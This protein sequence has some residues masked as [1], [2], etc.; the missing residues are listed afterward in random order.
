MTDVSQAN[1]GATTQGGDTTADKFKSQFASFKSQATDKA[2]DYAGQGVERATGALD[3]AA[4]FLEDT[5]RTVEE[6]LGPQYG[7]YGFSAAESVSGFAEQLRGKDVEELVDDV[8]SFVRKSPAVAIGAAVGLGFVLARLA[9]AGAGY[10]SGSAS[11]G[12]TGGST[13]AATR[14]SALG[15]TAT[16]TTGGPVGAPATTQAANQDTPVTPTFPA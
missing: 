10:E 2:R 12:N 1:D 6:K 14:G 3:E 9:K 13:G 8:R 11:F 5:A 4:K 16:G 7:R 15:D